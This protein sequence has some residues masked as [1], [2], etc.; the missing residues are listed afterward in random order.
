VAGAKSIISTAANLESQTLLLAYGGSD[1]FF[2]RF[3]PSKSFDSLPESFNKPVLI[4]VLLAMFFFL[5]KLGGMSKK[6][7]VKL[8][9]A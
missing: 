4:M 9:W 8:S 2:T 5:N 7:M 1:I 3:A 6:K